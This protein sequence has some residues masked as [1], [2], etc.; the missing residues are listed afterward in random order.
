MTPLRKLDW[1]CF[2]VLW[3]AGIIACAYAVGWILNC[4]IQ[5]MKGV[6]IQ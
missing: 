2:L 6:V 4:A 3:M 1:L 5:G